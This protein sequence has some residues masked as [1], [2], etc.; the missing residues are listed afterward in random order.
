M[1]I[2]NEKNKVEETGNIQ[3]Y[4]HTLVYGDSVIQLENIAM[5]TVAPMNKQDI[6]GWAIISAVLG[7]VVFSFN[8]MCGLLLML[9]GGGT[10]VYIYQKNCNLGHYL[11][12]ELNNGRSVYFQGRDESFLK[13]V[14]KILA[15]TINTE[16]DINYNLDLKN[17]KIDQMQVGDNN[18]MK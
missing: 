3:V 4:K 9:V 7:M 12:L 8:A 11:T 10:C 13:G 15:D 6:P 14:V 16:K 5:I 2:L 17:A 18:T 1:I